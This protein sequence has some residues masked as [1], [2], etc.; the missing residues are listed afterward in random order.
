MSTARAS[1]RRS[2]KIL[3]RS[4]QQLRLNSLLKY[5]RMLNLRAIFGIRRG[6]TIEHIPNEYVIE[7][8]QRRNQKVT[9][10]SVWQYFNRLLGV[11]ARS[12]LSQSRSDQW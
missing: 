11:R 1:A 8:R 6:A 2:L 4:P 3:N 7:E 9:Q 12:V 10:G 5:W